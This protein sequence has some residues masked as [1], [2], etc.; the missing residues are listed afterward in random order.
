LTVH[1]VALGR[2]KPLFA[3]RIRLRLLEARTFPS[4]VMINTYAPAE[5]GN[6]AQRN[7]PS[8]G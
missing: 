8:H 7:Q 6:T 5:N 4:G 2:G 1:P 3:D